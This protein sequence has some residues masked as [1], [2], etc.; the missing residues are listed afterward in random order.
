MATTINT[1][2]L[3]RRGNATEWASST[4]KLQPGEFG[5]DTT[6]TYVLPRLLARS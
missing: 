4:Y 1:I 6:N 5:F 3:A 2:L